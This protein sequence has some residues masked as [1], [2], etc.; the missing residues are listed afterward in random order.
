MSNVGDCLDNAV[1]ESFNATIKRELIDRRTWHS[2]D[3]VSTAIAEYILKWYNPYRYHSP[4][5]YK[6]PMEY[7]IALIQRIPANALGSAERSN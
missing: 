3:E 7:E 1:I 5:G 6:S 2:H 4:L